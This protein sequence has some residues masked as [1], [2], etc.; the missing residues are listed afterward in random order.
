M[1]NLKFKNIIFDFDGVLVE[2]L[3]VKSDA[4]YEIYLKFGKEIAE[5]VVNHHKLNSGISRYEKFNLYHSK[6]LNISLKKEQ[7]KILSDQFSRLVMEKV[8]MAD[9]V[10]GARDF[11]ER[12]YNDCYFWISSATP[13]QELKYIVAERGISTFFK[14]VYGFPNNK[15]DVVKD[16]INENSLKRDETLFVGDAK[17][18]YDAAKNNSINFFLRETPENQ[19]LQN[20][21]KKENCFNCFLDFEKKIKK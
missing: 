3:D 11:L 17:T 10:L 19:Y 18:D 12:N 1:D 7:V 13:E 2:S 5:K 9:E 14:K 16:I 21:L 20:L 6:F 15:T 4:F 8:V